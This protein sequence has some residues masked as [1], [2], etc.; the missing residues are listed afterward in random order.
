MGWRMGDKSYSRV[1]SFA[2]PFGSSAKLLGIMK[3]ELSVN[4]SNY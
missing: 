3:R 4:K 2:V 1:A